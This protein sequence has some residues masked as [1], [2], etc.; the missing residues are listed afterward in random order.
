MAKQDKKVY[1][2]KFNVYIYILTVLLL[3]IV[4]P[5]SIF[6]ILKLVGVGNL[7]SYYRWLDIVGIVFC[8]GIAVFLI[9]NL[10]LTKYIIEDGKF[11][12]QRFSKIEIP[13]Q[14]MLTIRVDEES[15]ITVLYYADDNSPNDGISFVVLSV[16]KKKEESLLEDI[17]AL[18]PYVSIERIPKRTKKE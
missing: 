11:I 16:S 8:L 9:L 12:K 18:N 15:D 7:V 6:T 4:I 3:L 14:K 2:F 13:T 1:Y 10:L 17:R 5:F